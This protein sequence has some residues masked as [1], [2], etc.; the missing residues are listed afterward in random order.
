MA[1]G[2]CA[3]R[4]PFAWTES[5][6]WPVLEITSRCLC[7]SH[8]ASR[9]PSI[10][11]GHPGTGQLMIDPPFGSIRWLVGLTAAVADGDILARSE[12]SR[13]DDAELEEAARDD[14][15]ELSW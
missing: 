8:R 4:V 14:N 6:L 3:A 7:A 13:P 11:A 5:R 10:L 2:A 12:S 9:F 1:A 15:S